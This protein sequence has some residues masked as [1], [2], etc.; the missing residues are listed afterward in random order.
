MITGA[1]CIS[2]V[3]ENEPLD[4]PL[5]ILTDQSFAAPSKAVRV[6]RKRRGTLIGNLI[7]ICSHLDNGRVGWK[8]VFLKTLQ[9][10]GI[11][12]IGL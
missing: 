8:Q 5:S 7:V 4:N 2:K 3:N 9:T 11:T 1:E 6:V 10:I 12:E